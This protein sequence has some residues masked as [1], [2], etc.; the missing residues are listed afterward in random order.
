MRAEDEKA[1]LEAPQS[2][3]TEELFKESEEL[4]AMM[5]A[6]GLMAREIANGPYDRHYE[7]TECRKAEQMSAMARMA[8]RKLDRCEK[9]RFTL[10]DRRRTNEG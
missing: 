8:I 5:W 3:L 10:G 7:M 1:G 4:G 2:C 6:A 9:L